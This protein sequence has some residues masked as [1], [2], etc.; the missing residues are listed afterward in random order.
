MAE[1][2]LEPGPGPGPGPGLG[3][4]PGPNPAEAVLRELALFELRCDGEDVAEKLLELSLT[5][6]LGPVPLANELLAFVTSKDLDPRLT[7]DSLAAFEHE[8]LARR[9]SRACRRSSSRHGGLR[10]VHSLQELLDEDEEE[11]EELLDAYTT[12]S[13]VKPNSPPPP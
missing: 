5:H 11:E 7:L 10:D 4:E 6:R 2:G 9:G 1:P 3:L 12:P 8:V 13:K